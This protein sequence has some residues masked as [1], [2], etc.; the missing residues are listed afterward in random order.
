[1]GW[2]WLWRRRLFYWE[3]RLVRELEISLADVR[4][5]DGV[6]D[7]LVWRGTA[8]GGF[9]AKFVYQFLAESNMIVDTVFCSVWSTQVQLKVAGCAWQVILQRLPVAHELRRRGILQRDQTNCTFVR[10]AQRQWII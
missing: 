6:D 10:I 3:G 4:L 2:E 9:L 8:N 5:V 1:V 7:K